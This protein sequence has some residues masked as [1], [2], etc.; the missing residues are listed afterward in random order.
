MKCVLLCAVVLTTFAI[1]YGN[2]KLHPLSDEFIKSINDKKTTWKA[3]RNFDANTPLP[4]IKNLL[5]VLPRTENPYKLPIKTHKVDLQAIPES[6]DAREAWP[7]C[8]SVIGNIRDQSECGSCWAFG[9]VEAMSDRICIHSNA[10]VKV[11]ISAED[12]LDCCGLCG[13]GCD[14]GWPEMAWYYWSEDGIVTGGNYGTTDGCKA[15]SFAPCEHHV[16]GDLPACGDTQPT[17]ACKKECDS[18]SSLTYQSDLT[19]GSAYGISSDVS[20]IQTEIMT[21]GPVEADYS[22]Y[23]DFLSYKSGVYQHVSGDMVGGHAIK[24]LGWGV[25]DDTPYWL[26]ANSWN[27]DWGDNGYFKILR[28]A[29]ECGIEGDILGGIPEL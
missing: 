10:T 14:G 8:A 1:T 12:L 13:M 25:E 23:A 9:A 17:P 26:V 6:F 2:K 21:N 16:D 11:S 20:Q 24:V 28:G 4:Q 3:G 7:E 19:H 5:G 18:G 27:E 22:V 29:N 15:Y